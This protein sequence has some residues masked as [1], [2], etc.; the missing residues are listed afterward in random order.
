MFLSDVAIRRPVFTAMLAMAMV[1]FGLLGYRG[2]AVDQFP[3]VDFPILLIQTIYPGASP[4][5]IERDVTKPI[6]DAVASTPGIDQ[7]QSFTRDSASMVV[8]RLEMGTDLT[9]AAANVRD[10][11]G[12]VQGEL[13]SGTELPVI[14]PIDLGALP[15]M[16]VALSSPRAVSY[17]HL[18]LPTN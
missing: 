7:L 11:V 14:R 12:A 8:V 4:E 10:R 17:T 3:P 6:E 15:V 13:P 1:V 5:D 9:A 2:L 16:V 18:T